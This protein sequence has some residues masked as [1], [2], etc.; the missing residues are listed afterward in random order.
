MINF[1]EKG[2]NS[3]VLL[4]ALVKAPKR[5][6]TGDDDDFFFAEELE[7]EVDASQEPAE[8]PTRSFVGGQKRRKAVVCR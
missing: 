1:T 8:I 2:V 7:G 4:D 3:I 6:Y 5:E